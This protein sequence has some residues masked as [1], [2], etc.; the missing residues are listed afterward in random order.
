M[1]KF[2]FFV[3]GVFLTSYGLTFIIIYLN[4]LNMGY[5]LFGYIKYILTH[6][7]C[8]II[9]LGIILLYLSFERK[10]KNELYL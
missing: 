1:K 3:A 9:I 10:D 8:L 2:F 5:T 4:L 6:F 7:E